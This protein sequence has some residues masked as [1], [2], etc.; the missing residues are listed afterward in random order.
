M[1]SSNNNLWEKH[2]FYK[3]NKIKQIKTTDSKQLYRVLDEQVNL[4]I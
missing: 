2:D 4:G 3:E 1:A